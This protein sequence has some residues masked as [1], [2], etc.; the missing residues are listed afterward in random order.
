M[1][2]RDHA[3]WFAR[4]VKA[5]KAKLKG[6]ASQVEGRHKLRVEVRKKVFKE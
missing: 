5:R 3:K 2:K 6:E 1:V 4:L